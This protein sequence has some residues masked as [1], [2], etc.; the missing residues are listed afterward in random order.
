MPNRYGSICKSVLISTAIFVLRSTSYAQTSGNKNG[1]VS[2]LG[3]LAESA[4]R[5][6]VA[7][8]VS[9]FGAD[10]NSGW[11]ESVP[12]PVI[13][14]LD[15]KLGIVGMGSFFSP[16]SKSFDAQGTFEFNHNQADL[17]IPRSYT[18]ALRDSIR[19]EIMKIPFNVTI[20]GPTIVGSK[21]DTIAVRFGGGTA[22]VNYSGTKQSVNLNPLVVSTGVTGFLENLRL[23]PMGAFQFSAGT[24]LG[25]DVSVRFLPTSSINSKL[26][27]TSYF[28]FGIQHD[29]LVWF[30]SPVPLNLSLAYF[31]QT[32]KIGS[33]FKSTASEFGIYAS[34]TF[35]PG[36]LNI[37]PFAGFSFESSKMNISY[38][39]Q[40]TGP[41]NQPISVPVSFSLTGEN[42]TSI[43]IG[44]SLRMLY[45][46]NIS[47]GYDVA[48]YNS[49]CLGVGIEI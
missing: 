41:L 29:P 35:G 40:T 19:S 9:G 44:F 46:V 23:L 5:G 32:L 48:K 1:L 11:V 47:V 30:G 10:L 49:A 31:T 39:F 6:Y 13:A 22:T 28:G 24:I 36:L 45:A 20:A 12:P 14:S 21:L 33:V 2:T 43:T 3:R 7:P 27:N 15:I 8:I 25:T 38:D 4:A 37:T 34:K 26:G 42:V 18:G 16:S 17:L